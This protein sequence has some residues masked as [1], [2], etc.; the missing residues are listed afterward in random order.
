MIRLNISCFLHHIH[1]TFSITF[2][3]TFTFS[4]T[5]N[6]HFPLHFQLLLHFHLL[7]IYI[8]LYISSHI[9][10]FTCFVFAFC[11]AFA[12]AFSFLVTCLLHFRLHLANPSQF[13]A[14]YLSLLFYVWNYCPTSGPFIRTD[15]IILT[16][17][18]VSGRVTGRASSRR[19]L[20]NACLTELCSSC[21]MCSSLREI[22]EVCGVHVGIED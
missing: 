22:E 13:L 8:L 15:A 20:C 4:L 14:P 2:P 21:S 1:F 10:I 19:C 6:L 16:P 5:M 3:I 11:F 17:I 7:W 12:R 9:Y 18:K